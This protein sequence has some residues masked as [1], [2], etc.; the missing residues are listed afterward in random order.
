MKPSFIT[1]YIAGAVVIATLNIVRAGQPDAQKE[2]ETVLKDY[3]AAMSARDA[4]GL[5]TVL[6]KHFVTVEATDKNARVHVVDTAI[7]K[8]LLPPEGN[9]DWDKDK[10]K[11]SAIEVKLSGT[12]PSVAIAS[13]TLEFPLSNQRVADLEA[14]LKQASAEFDEARR[15]AAEKIISDRAIHNSMFA[16]LARQ[17]GRWKIVSMTFPK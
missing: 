17:D 14:V 1:K 16:M 15:I 5:Q 12:H 7:S 2:I 9:D 8:G 10:M 11:L 3:F 4:K 6:G 13:F